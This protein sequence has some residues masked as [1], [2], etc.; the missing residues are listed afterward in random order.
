MN[1]K[2]IFRSIGFLYPA[3]IELV[4]QV[5]MFLL[6]ILATLFA[7]ATALQSAAQDGDSDPRIRWRIEVPGRALTNYVTTAPDGTIY[8]NSDDR[9]MAIDPDG[10]LQWEVLNTSNRESRPINV[11]ADGSLVVGGLGFGQV[12]ALNS[13]GS[14]LWA[15]NSS[16][17]RLLAGPSVGPDGNVYVVGDDLGTFSLDGT[18]NLRWIGDYYNSTD[19]NN[20]PIIFDSSRFYAGLAGFTPSVGLKVYDQDNGEEV[21]STASLGIP[22]SGHPVLDPSGRVIGPR[23]PTWVQA[24]DPED[25]SLVWS[26][27]HP[28]MVNFLLN[29]PKVGTNGVV[30]TSDRSGADL[31]AINPDGS[32]RWYH[33]HGPDTMAKVSI[34]PDDAV[35]VTQGLTSDN[36]TGTAARWFRGYDATN[37]D[38][39]WQIDLPDENGISPFFPGFDVAFTPDSRTAYI[40]TSYFPAAG[41]YGYLY[42]IDIGTVIY[43]D[44][45]LDGVVNLLDVAPFIDRVSTGEYQAEADINQDGTVNLLD[46]QPFVVLLGA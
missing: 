44:V 8:V 40:T 2:K 1:D 12:T 11:R 18:G 19:Q 33:P 3:K 17:N 7:G 20:S 5:Q 27:H 23:F 26:A 24:L 43:G 34:S 38:F 45:N 22:W 14:L 10:N 4:G 39:L 29:Q 21:W 37:G 32:T 31:W 6:V 36:Q 25:G 41:N 46:V 15:Y 13:D 9:L 16:A 30:Y 28:G 42:A 35:I